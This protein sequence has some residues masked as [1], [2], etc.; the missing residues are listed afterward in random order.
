MNWMRT[1]GENRRSG[2][3]IRSASIRSRV[4]RSL[5]PS[6]FAI[7]IP[8][9]YSPLN[10]ALDGSYRTI[11]L[12]VTGSDK[13]V[14]RT[15]SGLPVQHRTTEVRPI[16]SAEKRR[17]ERKNTRI[18]SARSDDLDAVVG[19]QRKAPF[20]ARKLARS[21]RKHRRREKGP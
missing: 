13:F 10:Q 1:D 3:A 5:S 15:S 16:R 7:S 6:R 21:S 2:R 18:E 20:A 17:P 8:I 12:T 9:A 11:R 4:S 19:Q 14:V